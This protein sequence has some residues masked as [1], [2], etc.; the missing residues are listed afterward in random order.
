MALSK[1]A[2][3]FQYRINNTDWSKK[4]KI[5]VPK[6]EVEIFCYYQQE[7][8]ISIELINHLMGGP[9]MDYQA[10]DVDDSFQAFEVCA[11][12]VI[13][14]LKESKQEI[15]FFGH[16]KNSTSNILAVVTKQEK[17]RGVREHLVLRCVVRLTIMLTPCV[18]FCRYLNVKGQCHVSCFFPK[19]FDQFQKKL[20]IIN[21]NIL[22]LMTI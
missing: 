10:I 6:E 7:N 16:R 2:G 14:Y 4:I 5:T 20:C 21:A 17:S 12:E 1:P 18:G 11:G 22:I 19:I 15:L 3:S 13:E 9:N 8:A